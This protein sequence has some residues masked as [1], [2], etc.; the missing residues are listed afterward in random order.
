MGGGLFPS[1][2]IM[3]AKAN[4][5]TSEVVAST[6]SLAHE[7]HKVVLDIRP[8][9]ASVGSTGW[10]IPYWRSILL[11]GHTG[12]T[13][14]VSEA[15]VDAVVHWSAAL[16]GGLNVANGNEW[17]SWW[18]CILL[19]DECRVLDISTYADALPGVSR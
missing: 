2:G 16:T 8:D 9:A 18:F 17:L 10:S 6:I 11:G 7:R 1:S 15:V 14:W 12:D 4:G 13:S 3:E 5:I 19:A